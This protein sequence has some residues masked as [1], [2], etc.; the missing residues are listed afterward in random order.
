MDRHTCGS[1]VATEN[2]NERVIENL[3]CLLTFGLICTLHAH[4]YKLAFCI[5][6]LVENRI[7]NQ[8]HKVLS[9]SRKFYV[10]SLVLIVDR[11]FRLNFTEGCECENRTQTQFI[12]MNVFTWHNS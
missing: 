1:Q 11:G 3:N 4:K 9:I 10:F 8:Q 12:V 5:S 7:G 6:Y 2:S